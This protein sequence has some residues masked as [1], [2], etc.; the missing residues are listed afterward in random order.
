MKKSYLFYLSL[1]LSINLLYAQ[2]KNIKSQPQSKYVSKRAAA[3][4]QAVANTNK[5]F[6]K[7]REF[8]VSKLTSNKVNLSQTNFDDYIK[9]QGI[10]KIQKKG[11]S[12]SKDGKKIIVN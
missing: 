5:Q 6:A 9:N 11:F 8:N 3:F 1:I 10:K 7:D 2:S 4:K 12:I